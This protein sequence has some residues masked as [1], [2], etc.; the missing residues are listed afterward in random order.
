MDDSYV[1]AV[2]GL[3]GYL[4]VSV[5]M[6]P[7]VVILLVDKQHSH[8]ACPSSCS[9]VI[10]AVADH[11]Q[12]LAFASF[13]YAPAACNV[14]DPGRVWLWWRESSGDDRLESGL[15]QEC[16]QKVRDGLTGSY[17]HATGRCICRR[18]S[19]GLP[20]RSSVCKC[21][22]E[23]LSC[24]GI[25]SIPEDPAAAFALSW[26]VAQ[27]RAPSQRPLSAPALADS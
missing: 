20:T 12:I 9:H 21:P 26:H 1:Y 2:T 4:H 5:L 10:D 25:A 16:I 19:N 24:R 27:S 8:R 17:Q 7:Q 18:H 14:K 3:L 15:R 6:R 11:D 13:R 22:F 23:C